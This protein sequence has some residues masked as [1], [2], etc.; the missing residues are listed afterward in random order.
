VNSRR[1]DANGRLSVPLN[2]RYFDPSLVGLAVGLR[3]LGQWLAYSVIGDLYVCRIRCV[4]NNCAR[5]SCVD[6]PRTQ[7]MYLN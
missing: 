1:A 5:A 6:A 4:D 2:E 3:L 7:H